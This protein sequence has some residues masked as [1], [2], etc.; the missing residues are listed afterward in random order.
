MIDPVLLTEV[1]LPEGHPRASEHCPVFGFVIWHRDG[2]VLVDTGLGRGHDAVEALFAPRHRPIDDALAERGIHRGDVVMVINSHLHFD[3]CGNNRS[4]RRVPMVVQRT[5]YELAHEPRYTIP[6]WVDFPDAQWELVEGETEVLPGVRVLPTPGHTP[7][8]QSVVIETPG[9]VVVVAGQAL[10]DPGE[11]EA[12][13]SIEPL[14]PDEAEAT[15]V[16]ARAIKSLGPTTVYFS[17]Y[18][19]TWPLTDKREAS[20]S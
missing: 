4:F 17:H 13:E 1:I 20:V 12:E 8:H 18:L 5:E 11:L 3:H 7:G 10:Y 14:T 6:E 16:S 19:G 9:S 2:P 15:S